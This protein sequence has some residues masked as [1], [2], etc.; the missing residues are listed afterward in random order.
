MGIFGW[1]LPPGC[2]R[3]PAEEEGAYELQIDGVWYAW[4]SNG[5]VYEYTGSLFER[6]DGYEFFGVYPFPDA[7]ESDPAAVLTNWVKAN[8]K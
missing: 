2:G 7:P 4:E 8:E 3:L 6:D 1:S 5:D